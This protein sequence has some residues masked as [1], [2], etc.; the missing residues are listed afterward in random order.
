M[1]SFQLGSEI[2][3]EK[4]REKNGMGLKKKRRKGHGVGGMNDGADP[5]NGPA[6]PVLTLGERNRSG[7]LLW[8]CVCCGR[9]MS[10][11]QLLQVT[12]L[13]PRVSVFQTFTMA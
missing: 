6:S 9:A 12:L 1:E 3:M 2:G 11:L 4:S 5:Q 8:R 7:D 13:L 10:Y